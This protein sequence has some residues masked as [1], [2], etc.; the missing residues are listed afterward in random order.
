MYLGAGIVFGSVA[1][2]VPVAAWRICRRAAAT[3]TC[4][5]GFSVNSRNRPRR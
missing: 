3:R 4:A 1:Y 5:V 2:L